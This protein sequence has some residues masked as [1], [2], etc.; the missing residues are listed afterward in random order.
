MN[1]QITGPI[2][3]WKGPSPWYF[4][5]VPEQESD[6]LH[7]I[8]KEVTYGWGMI[9]VTVQIDKTIWQTALFPYEGKYVVPIKSA[10]RKAESIA[11]D[12]K[13][14]LKILVSF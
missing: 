4:V 6:L 10:V 2:W 8:S 12:D 1:F 13:V 5:T 11:E 7:G 3:H 9:P 14:E